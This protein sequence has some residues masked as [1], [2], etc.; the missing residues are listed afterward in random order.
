MT[1]ES[2]KD[3]CSK[4][5]QRPDN[6][7]IGK[8]VEYLNEN[9][10]DH[11]REILIRCGKYLSGIHLEKCFQL[12]IE[13]SN[14]EFIRIYLENIEDLPED[15][16]IRSLNISFANIQCLL[17][18]SFDY[19][20]LTNA[21]KIHL[22]SSKS[23]ELANQLVNELVQLENKSSNIIDWLCALIDSHFSSFVLAKWNK[24]DL[25]EKLV[26]DRLTTFDFLQGLN[27]IDH[28]TTNFNNKSK[29]SND[30]YSLQRIH[31]K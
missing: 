10:I 23:V 18:K 19:W 2:W 21:M 31:F 1:N 11:H 5:E 8:L 25:I 4:I 13:Q 3:L 7:L 27:T 16:L 20:S 9:N 12:L 28:S 30:L 17:I 14:E 15:Q 26:Q 6:S 22:N 29:K 24:I